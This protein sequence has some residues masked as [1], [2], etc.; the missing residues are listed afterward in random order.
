[1]EVM[2]L[3]QVLD[4]FNSGEVFSVRYVSLDKKRKTGG[5]IIEMKSVV[6]PKIKRNSTV[7]ESKKVSVSKGTKNHFANATRTVQKVA[8]G[9]VTSAVKSVHIFLILEVNGKKMVL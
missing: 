3:Q 8:D 5:K 2:N 6:C 9:H 1:M 7:T 4:V